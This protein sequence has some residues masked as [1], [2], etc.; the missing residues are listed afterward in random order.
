M[1]PKEHN[2]EWAKN[3]RDQLRTAEKCFDCTDPVHKQVICGFLKVFVRCKKCLKLMRER[4][5]DYRER[6]QNAK[7]SV[8]NDSSRNAGNSQQKEQRLLTGG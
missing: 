4:Q 1:M 3:R 5:Q 7:R 6:K 2:K 8:Q